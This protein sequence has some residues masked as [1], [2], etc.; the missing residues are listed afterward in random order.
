MHDLG[1]QTVLCGEPKMALRMAMEQRPDLIT[2]DL[3]MPGKSGWD[4]LA[5]LKAEPLLREIPVV[6]VSIV[7]DRKKAVSLGAVDAL[8]KPILRHEFQ[9]CI[10]RNFHPEAWRSGRVLVVEDDLTRSNCC[11]TG[12]RRRSEK[13]AWWPT[14]RKRWRCWKTTGPTW[15]SS[16]CKCQ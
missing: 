14:G 1:A 4:V 16:I 12:S 3:M 13:F 9:A 7:A 8:S 5:E 11:A 2:L 15:S 6:I 10:E